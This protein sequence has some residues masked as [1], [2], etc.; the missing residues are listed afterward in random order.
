M[1]FAFVLTR[2]SSSEEQSDNTPEETVDVHDWASRI[3][4]KCVLH[5]ATTKLFIKLAG[6]NF[7]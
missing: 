6:G 2:H 3:Q 7:A 1:Q 5:G 4:R